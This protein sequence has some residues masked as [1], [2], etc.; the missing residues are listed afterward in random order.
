MPH[1]SP[2]RNAVIWTL[3][4]VVY[5][6]TAAC[7]A[8]TAP[9]DGAAQERESTEDATREVTNASLAECSASDPAVLEQDAR[10]YAKDEGIS[11]EEA[12]RQ[13]RVQGCFA[14]DLTDLECALRGEEAGTF[15]G[16]WIR[17]GPQ[18]GFVV[19]FTRDGEQ[20]IRPYLKGEPERFRRL[21]EVRSGANATLTELHAAQKEATRLVNELGIRAEGTGINVEKNHAVVY[22][23]NKAHFKAALREAGAQLPDNVEVVDIEGQMRPE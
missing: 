3:L 7:A 13:L 1:P 11:V 23:T 22:A 18:Y 2:A 19:L 9:Q 10:A 8:G 16:L 12:E 20:T 15:A 21:I 17:R 14:D 6:S 4:V 5:L